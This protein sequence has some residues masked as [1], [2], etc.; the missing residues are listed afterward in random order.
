MR[1]NVINK[2]N[3]FIP[4]LYKWKIVLI[5]FLYISL[6]GCQVEVPKFHDYQGAIK[7]AK[8]INRPVL[9]VFTAYGLGYNEFENDFLKSWKLSNLLNKEFVVIEMIVDDPRVISDEHKND[10]L[11][12]FKI[13]TESNKVRNFGDLNRIIQMSEYKT[14]SQPL[15]V[16]LNEQEKLL[17]EPFGHQGSNSKFYN[18][19]QIVLSNQKEKL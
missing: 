18:K 4:S 5:T 2:E 16:I 13:Q 15:Y 3:R 6:N 19:L 8:E 12:K 7:Y 9:I 14:N 11:T 10:M 1:I 17:I